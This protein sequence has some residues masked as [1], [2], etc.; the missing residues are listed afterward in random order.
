MWASAPTK[1]QGVPAGRA[2][3]PGRMTGT[4]FFHFAGAQETGE[5]VLPQGFVGENGYGVTEV[6]AAGLLSHGQADAAVIMGLTERRRQ[7][8]GL[9]AEKEPAIRRKSGLGIVLRCQ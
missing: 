3:T 2:I 1:G 9:L 6:E 5:A 8:G 7:A 4:L